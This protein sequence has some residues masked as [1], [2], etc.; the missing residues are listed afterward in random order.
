MYLDAESVI[1]KEPLLQV[2]LLSFE[3]EL[4]GTFIHALPP[5]I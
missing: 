3:S 5:F 2:M 4:D 1:V